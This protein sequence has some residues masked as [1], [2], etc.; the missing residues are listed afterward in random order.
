MHRAVYDKQIE[1]LT[2]GDLEGLIS[3]YSDNA[4][5]IRFDKT[6]SGKENLREFFKEYLLHLGTFKLISTDK[7]TET[8]DALFFEATVQSNLGIA[9]IYDVFMLNNEGKITHHFAGVISIS[10][11]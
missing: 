9:K 8:K 4:N 5:L 3:Q 6:I 11:P 7:Y 2:A 10:K 1:Y